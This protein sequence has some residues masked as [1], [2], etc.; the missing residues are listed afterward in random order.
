MKKKYSLI[1]LILVTILLSSCD[2]FNTN[3][4]DIER[5]EFYHSTRLSQVPADIEEIMIIFVFFSVMIIIF[6]LQNIPNI[7]WKLREKLSGIS[8]INI[9]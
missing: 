8:M 4:E 2:I 7:I 6:S 1:A 5:A 3:F 9:A